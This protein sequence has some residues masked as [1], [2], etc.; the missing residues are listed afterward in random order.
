M[1]KLSDTASQENSVLRSEI[2]RLQSELKGYKKRLSS[3]ANGL[4]T[5]P[6]FN[7]FSS[8][9]PQGTLSGHMSDFQ[10]DFP[11]FGNTSRDNTVALMSSSN[12]N[13]Y[14]DSMIASLSGD[15][16]G[17]PL[18]QSP[19]RQSTR[20]PQALSFEPGILRGLG[21]VD[22]STNFDPSPDTGNM[23][24]QSVTSRQN[25]QS[26]QSHS[27]SA[28][29]MDSPKYSIQNCASSCGT[30]PEPILNYNLDGPKTFA[31][32]TYDQSALYQ[33]RSN[34]QSIVAI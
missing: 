14:T 23:V 11:R 3:S 33:G 26:T 15:F 31:D 2:Q 9:Q 17:Q 13:S 28:S 18:T 27:G 8:S 7:G 10:F 12:N 4:S 5:S 34:Q 24:E 1:E 25:S 19:G 21:T 32:L 30:S 20:D 16:S 22:Y 6:T 29:S